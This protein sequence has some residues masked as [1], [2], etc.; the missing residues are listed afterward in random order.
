MP[1]QFL[2]RIVKALV[3]KPDQVKI[4]EVEGEST[5]I[6]Q[7]RVGRGDYGRV[8]GREGQIAD[9]IQTLLRAVVFSKKSK[10]AILEI[11]A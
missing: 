8:V 7:L 10:H 11:L 2:E 6:Y 5:I 3:D 4:T 9:S 1:K